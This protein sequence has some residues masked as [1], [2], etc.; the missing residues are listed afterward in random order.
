MK[1]SINKI[2]VICFKALMLIAL[3]GLV[4]SC[5]SL[6]EADNPNNLLEEDLSDPRSLGPMVNG[7]QVTVTRAM[8][9]MLTPYSA[10]SDEMIWIG[11]R[12]AWQQLN[13][14]N[15]GDPSNEFTDA[16]FFFVGEARWWADEV[17]KRMEVFLNEGTLISGDEGK[18][19]R[20]YYYGA[21]I[22]IMIADMFDDFVISSDKLEPGFPVGPGSMNTLYDTALGYLNKALSSGGASGDLEAAILGTI[23]RAEFSKGVWANTNGG[24]GLVDNGA[25]STA[26]ETALATMSAISND[27]KW[28]L[29]VTTPDERG[30]LPIGSEVNSRLETRLS[31]NYVIS[32]GKRVANIDDGDP[33]TS[34]SL[35]DPIDDI[36][37]PALH[38]LVKAF[39]DAFISPDYIITSSREMHLIMAEVA[40]AQ[41]KIDDFTTHINNLRALDGKT[42]FS[43]QVDA[44]ELLIHE[45]KVNLFLQARRIADHYRFNDPSP[46]WVPSGDAI[47]SPGTFF[48]ITISEIRANPNI[49]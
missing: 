16:A 33:E 45:R 34:I 30:G 26:A 9:N 24:S 23:A 35:R 22:Y 10:A 25:A 12:D 5:D 8:G 13:F 1:L 38:T 31:D 42:A 48:P 17:I 7:V 4:P 20:A 44:Q 49:N 19:A 27:F 11:S 32:D 46:Q 2:S 14:G 39:A 41:N 36:A 21:I 37:D 40:L 28:S 6:L 47:S 15:I 18:V 3:V 29:S 43:G